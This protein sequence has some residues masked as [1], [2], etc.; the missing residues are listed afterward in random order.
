M[1]DST[2]DLPPEQATADARAP[3]P[4]APPVSEQDADRGP[5]GARTA[6]L[7]GYWPRVGGYLLDLVIVLLGGVVVVAVL[8]AAR[9]AA[10]GLVLAVAAQFV[11]A[12][13]MIGKGHGQTLGMRVANV[14]CVSA[15]DGGEITMARAAGRS[16]AAYLFGLI[17]LVGPLLDLLWPAWD[18][19]HQTLHDK[20]AGT[21]VIATVPRTSSVSFPQP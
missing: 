5:G 21:V 13:L 15:A 3:L 11:Y 4:F 19:K 9:V 14:R 1:T 16:A 8:T 10:L 2:P 12:W 7:A 18:A 20:L 17:Y 6:E